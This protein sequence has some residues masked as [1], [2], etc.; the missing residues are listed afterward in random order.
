MRSALGAVLLSVLV[1]NLVG[2]DD[3]RPTPPRPDLRGTAPA[4]ARPSSMGSS[5]GHAREPF[6]RPEL[7][8]R[9]RPTSP[10]R[11]GARNVTET[12]DLPNMAE[13]PGRDLGAELRA[14][15][16]N[17]SSCI[18]RGAANLPQRATLQVNAHV[19]VT[20]IITRAYASTPGFPP[21]MSRC[22]A[23]RAEGLHLRGPIPDAPRVVHAS[24][25]IAASALDAATADGATPRA[26]P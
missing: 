19:S 4:V 3:D 23:R 9:S 22:L 17:P 18:P 12:R 5:T 7:D 26:Q 6:R 16:G 1:I 20:G 13:A 14:A 24:L 11:R 21:E 25:E 2:C 15:L 10:A 8:L